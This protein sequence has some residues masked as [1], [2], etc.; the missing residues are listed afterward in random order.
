MILIINKNLVFLSPFVLFSSNIC[1]KYD[2][3]VLVKKNGD[4]LSQ[5]PPQRER[6]N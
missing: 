4:G 2:C 5:W 3:L 6:K 1:M